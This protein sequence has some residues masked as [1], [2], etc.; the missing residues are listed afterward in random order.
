MKKPK[1]EGKQDRNGGAYEFAVANAVCLLLR[2]A[3]NVVEAKEDDVWRS[4]KSSFDEI[5]K[6]DQD[7]MTNSGDQAMQYIAE[8]LEPMILSPRS[9]PME[10]SLQADD[11]GKKG[12]VRDV[13]MLRS[14]SGWSLGVSVKHNSVY[15]RS[16][17]L[18]PKSGKDFFTKFGIPC[19]KEYEKEADIPFAYMR[20]HKGELW[21]DLGLAKET[22]IYGPHLQAIVNEIERMLP[23]PEL[24]KRLMLRLVGSNDCYKVIKNKSST[25]IEAININGTLNSAYGKIQA[26][27]K[28]AEFPM[29]TKVIRADFKEKD[30]MRNTIEVEFDNGL[31]ISLR[32]K[33]KDSKIKE[34]GIAL[35]CQITKYPV[36]YFMVKLDAP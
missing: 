36:D 19:S 4:A 35:E 25:T 27:T 28:V 17:R 29:P 14:K 3:G 33:N 24:A 34:A 2:K 31:A 26:K 9:E 13:I 30:G 7:A 32:A 21:S 12:D 20:A 6:P 22:N 23:N 15:I 10:L 5:S 11:K 18:S 1:A 8:Y 16:L